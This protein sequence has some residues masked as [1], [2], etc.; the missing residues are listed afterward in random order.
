M[1]RLGLVRSQLAAHTPADADEER[2]LALFD[3]EVERL[4]GGGADPFDQRDD[5]VHITGSAIVV[6]P[7][8][9]VLLEHRRLGMW[10]QPGG[11]ID[12]GETPWAAALREAAEETGLAV[13]FPSPG[14]SLV[15]VDVHAGGRGHTHLDLRYLVEG[16]EGDPA[17]PEGE[18]QEVEWFDWPAAIRRAGDPRLAALLA[19]LSAT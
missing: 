10:L 17:P 14:P 13:A 8:G 12:P 5:P 9:T 1:D 3:S 16:G 15:H 2:S 4:V 6:G 7:R 18:S 11:H 19:R